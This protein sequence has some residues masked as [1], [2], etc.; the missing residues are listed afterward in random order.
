MDSTLLLLGV[1]AAALWPSVVGYGNGEGAR[2]EAPTPVLAGAGSVVALVG[3]N[4][5]IASGGGMEGDTMLDLVLA[6]EVVASGLDDGGLVGLVG[7]AWGGEGHG[8]VPALNLAL[9]VEAVASGLADSGMV[10]LIGRGEGREG[11]TLLDPAGLAVEG[12]AAWPCD[13]GS[14]VGLG[15]ALGPARASVVGRGGG[16]R[17]GGGAG[18]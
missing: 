13:G 8:G 17:G 5:A 11:V 9:V 15:S 10:G 1:S 12:E 2:G 7:N 18:A 6:A 14:T 3:A 16:G 4:F